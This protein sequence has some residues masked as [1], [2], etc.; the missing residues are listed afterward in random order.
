MIAW[1]QA[2]GVGLITIGSFLVLVTS[3]GMTRLH[4]LYARMHASTK[5]QVLGVIVMCAGLACVMQKSR[6]S[7]TLLLVVIMQ[8]IVAPISAHM[9]GRAVYRLK[10][11]DREVI[12]SDEYGE[13][14]ERAQRHLQE[15][16][17]VEG[18]ASGDP[19]PPPTNNILG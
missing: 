13:D 5:P 16:G 6:V 2:V 17:E 11:S 8:L 10:Q 9:L 19:M 1:L 12:V 15:V 3:V 7:W 14:L 18:V 4:S